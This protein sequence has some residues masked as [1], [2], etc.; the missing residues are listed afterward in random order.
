[1]A[2]TAPLARNYLIGGGIIYAVLFV[3]GLVI[4]HESAANF[5]PLNQA[6]NWLHLILAIGM[7]GLGV[8]LGK[9]S[10]TATSSPNALGPNA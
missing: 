6:D 3:Y 2:R 4:D 5:V 7:I 9:R 10:L 1:M 8:L